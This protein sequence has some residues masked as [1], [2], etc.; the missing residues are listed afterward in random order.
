MLAVSLLAHLAITEAAPDAQC[1]FFAD[2]WSVFAHAFEDLQKSLDA[3][4]D[5]TRR[6]KMKIAPKKSWTWATSST[7][8][9]QCASLQVDSIR[10]PLVHSAH[11]LGMQQN[12][13]KK[14]SKKNCQIKNW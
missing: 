6:L 13:T 1:A 3:L 2:N 10:I 14:Q 9:T 7:L 11:D 8:R 5:V 4:H 12:Y